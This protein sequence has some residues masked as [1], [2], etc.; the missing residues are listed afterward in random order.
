[1]C[2]LIPSQIIT[3]ETKLFPIKD[4]DSVFSVIVFDLFCF[5]FIIT[6]NE[7]AGR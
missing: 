3:W 6:T 1:M 5:E 7:V 2:N 4:D